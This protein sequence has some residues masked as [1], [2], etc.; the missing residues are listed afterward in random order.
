MQGH[1]MSPMYWLAVQAGL[2]DMVRQC[3]YPRFFW[4]KSPYE[5]SFP[6]HQFLEDQLKKEL[7]ARVGLPLQET[8]HIAHVLTQM[9]AGA[10][11]GHNCK[12][13]G[14]EWQRH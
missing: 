3:G 4:T 1:P 10:I 6:Y 14:R 2:V 12:R 13:A 5:A 8:L 7:R 11:A 9:A